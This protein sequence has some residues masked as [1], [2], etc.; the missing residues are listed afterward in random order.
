VLSSTS[1]PK[2]LLEGT[3]GIRVELSGIR[4]ELSGTSRPKR[5]P[6]ELIGGTCNSYWNPDWACKH[7]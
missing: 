2:R 3:S 6:V 4:V 7:L 5:M 1:R